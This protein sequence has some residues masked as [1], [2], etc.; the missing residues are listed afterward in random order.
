MVEDFL[1]HR[2]RTVECMRRGEEDKI[3]SPAGQSNGPLLGARAVEARRPE[4]RVHAHRL[5]H[6]PTTRVVDEQKCLMA[7]ADSRLWKGLR[8]PWRK[9]KAVSSICF[10]IAGHHVSSL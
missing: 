3:K 10:H 2:T 4:T 9:S 8:T 6:T 1:V 5:N 7:Q